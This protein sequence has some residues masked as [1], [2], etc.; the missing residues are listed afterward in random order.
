[1]KYEQEKQQKESEFA[2]YALKRCT[3]ITFALKIP[4]HW[5]R[6]HRSLQISTSL[7]LRHWPVHSKKSI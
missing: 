6:P 2:Y 3:S 7:I 5:P 4:P 1:M